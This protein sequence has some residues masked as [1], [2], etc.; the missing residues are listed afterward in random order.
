MKYLLDT[1]VVSEW[2]KPRPDAGVVGWLEQADEDRAF[3]SVVTVTELRYGIERLPLSN[4]RKAL[5]DWM[6]NELLLRFESRILAIDPAIADACGKLVAQSEAMGR[7]LELVDAFL[8]A[9]ARVNQLTL[10]TRNVEH[11][12][13]FLRI[14]VNP[15]TR[16]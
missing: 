13:P 1:N 4:R 9:T 10:V 5:E 12:Q 14:I 6:E 11:F 8:A 3:L 2:T 15:W 7:Q 16:P